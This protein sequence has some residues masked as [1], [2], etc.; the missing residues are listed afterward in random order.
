MN[1]ATVSKSDSYSVRPEDYFVLETGNSKT[2]TMPRPENHPGR[3][4]VLRDTG[5]TGVVDFAGG[6]VDG[7]STGASAAL[8]QNKTFGY[9][10]DGTTW[11]TLFV[12]G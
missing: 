7:G 3:V 11:R 1:F 6:S 8:T 12:Q 10:S 5:S 2:I 9:I 4:I